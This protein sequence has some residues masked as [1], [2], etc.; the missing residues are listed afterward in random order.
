MCESSEKQIENREENR[1]VSVI[2][3][4]YNVE[5]YLE[6]CLDSIR[7]QTY[8][9][10]EIILVDD[11]TEDDSGILCDVY[12]KLDDRIKVIHKENGG[13]LNA[14]NTG[15]D[16]AKG[17]YIAF[18]DGDDFIHPKMYETMVHMIE[19]EQSDM[20]FCDFQEVEKGEKAD[21]DIEVIGQSPEFVTGRRMQ[22]LYFYSEF[23]KIMAA[24]WNK[25]YKA[26]MF[27]EVRFQEGWMCEDEF[28]TCLLTYP[29]KKVSYTPT[30]FYYHVTR[31]NKDK[32]T[33]AAES[34]QMFDTYLARISYFAENKEYRLTEKFTR[35]YMEMT[36]KYRDWCEEQGVECS[37]LLGSCREGLL[38]IIVAAIREKK[39]RFDLST[40][41]EMFAYFYV[42]SLYYKAWRMAYK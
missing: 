22:N 32:E 23:S 39:I 26:S 15:L 27:Q 24:T 7:R 4:V 34:F 14:R 28:T 1:T 36:N 41:A 21:M 19:T 13:K 16:V 11:G 3:P 2:V 29:C 38:Q 8:K 35:R 17:K 31:N 33:L 42:N 9:D 37:E 10:L 18:V 5:Q 25:L 6:K 12:T 20:V 30:P 40:N